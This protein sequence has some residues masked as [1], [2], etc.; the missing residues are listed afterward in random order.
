MSEEM[1]ALFVSTLAVAYGIDYNVITSM[2][3]LDFRHRLCPYRIFY[4]RIFSRPI[5]AL[6]AGYVHCLEETESVRRN[7]TIVN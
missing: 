3:M 2:M 1:S 4:P 7:K 5:L 6:V